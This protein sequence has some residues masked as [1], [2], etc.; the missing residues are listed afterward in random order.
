VSQPGT[1]RRYPAVARFASASHPTA[2]MVG[3]G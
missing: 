2:V 3:M 1:E